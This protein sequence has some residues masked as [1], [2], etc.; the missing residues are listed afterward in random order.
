MLRE[1]RQESF[2]LLRLA[3]AEPRFDADSVKLVQDQFVS[4]LKQADQSP[5]SVASRTLLKA[6]FGD[7]PYGRP[8][9]G[10]VAGVEAVTVDDLRMQARRQFARD[11]LTIAIVGDVTSEEAAALVDGTFGNLPETTGEAV[12]PPWTPGPGRKGGRTLL[13]ER[14]VPQSV[15]LIALPSIKRDD[16]DWYA[17]T[18]MNHVL[19]G[20][21]FSGRLMNEVRE[22][23]G[24]AYGAYSRLSTYRQAGLLI[25]SVG[26]ANER[27]A[28]SVRIIHEQ[29]A[30][31]EKDGVS[32]AELAD[33]KAYLKGSLALSLQSTSEI[34]SL[35]HSMQVDGLPPD[36][37]VRRQALIDRVSLDDVKRMA[38]RILRE[39]ASVTVVVGK[40][41]GISPSE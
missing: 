20:G 2:D 36:H 29:F 31:M 22:K 35:L 17:A 6:M 25:A 7:H 39:D 40:P 33:A 26:T 12:A 34:A 24:L 30:L 32:E 27:V 38:K 1:F 18:V 37:L 41:K 14:D 9:D 15:A 19:G 21:G 11:R 4:G 3:L 16:P 13:V 10:T 5:S 8:V 23:R 28:E